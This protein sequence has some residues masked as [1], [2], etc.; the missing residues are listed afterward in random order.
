MYMKQILFH[1]ICCYVCITAFTVCKSQLIDLDAT[2]TP[3]TVNRVVDNKAIVDEDAP[4]C[5]PGGDEALLEFLDKNVSYPEDFE[6]CASGRV[7]VSFT[8][9]VDGSIIEPKVEKSVCYEL[10]REAIRVVGLM[11]KWVPAKENGKNIKALHTI[12]VIFK[13]R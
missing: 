3:A 10:D 1:Y 12:S 9:D 5:F 13:L 4:P 8:V 2:A 6:G 11:P 7:I